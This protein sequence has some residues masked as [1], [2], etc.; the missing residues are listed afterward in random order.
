MFKRLWV[1]PMALMF[2]SVLL[3]SPSKAQEAKTGIQISPLS[4]DFE[5]R[6]GASQSGKFTLK[7]LDGA[8]MN[9]VLETELFESISEDGA[10][11]FRGVTKPD[12]VSTLAD[13]IKF[14]SPLE[15]TLE[16]YSSLDINFTI[17][18]PANA[19]PGGH[20]AAIFARQVK[21]DAE[22]KTQL[23]VA[24]RVGLLTLV[25][26]PGNV[27]KT[28]MIKSFSYPSFIWKGPTDFALKFE[29]TGSIHYESTAKVEVK[30]LLGKSREVDL[31]KHTVIPNSIRAYGGTWNSKY[32]FGYYK[33]TAT[34]TDGAGNKVSATGVLWAIPLMIVIP[35][36]L[37]ALLIWGILLYIRQNFQVVR[38]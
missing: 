20:Y 19:E 5:I 30:P 27:T 35:I 10:P 32:P 9:Y 4:Y 3:V 8:V 26:V 11:A 18:T 23:G 1:Y 29:N 13:W 7:N 37:L 24:S 25:S 28:G 16:P 2:A 17:E 15:G 34:S 12:G 22:G 33:L 36:I 21:K 31:G 14:S 38:K 6:P